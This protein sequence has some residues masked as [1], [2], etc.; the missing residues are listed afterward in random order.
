MSDRLL[1]SLHDILNDTKTAALA[2][3]GGVDSMLLAYLATQLTSNHFTVFHAV[4]PAVSKEATQRV[5]KYS[6][7]YN[8]NLEKINAGEFDDENYIANPYNRC[9]YCKNNLYQTIGKHTTSVIFSGANVSDLSDFRPGLLAA[10]KYGVRHPYIEAGIDKEKIREIA[11]MMNLTDLA[12]LPAQPCL[13]S[14]IKT[15]L[16]I[17]EQLLPLI[18][19]AENDLSVLF[20]GLDVRCRIELNSIRV[21][22]C[23]T[24]FERLVKIKK[25]DTQNCARSFCRNEG[26]CRN[27]SINRALRK[28]ICICQTR[29][30]KVRP[31]RGCGIEL[32]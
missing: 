29:A 26:Y 15:G 7:A 11:K 21:E 5:S 6:D 2:V 32:Y 3:S 12:E 8:W 20:E 16:R 19:Q 23:R 10:E 24:A 17:E 4:S 18:N 25:Q 14:R 31:D 30:H 22:I 1:S 9:F 28:R 27:R 13:S